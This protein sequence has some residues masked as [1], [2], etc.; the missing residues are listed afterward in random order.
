MKRDKTKVESFAKSSKCGFLLCAILCMLACISL[1]ALSFSSA[2]QTAY[3]YEVVTYNI[4]QDGEKVKVVNSSTNVVIYNEATFKH[5]A[6][7]EAID[8]DR[9][10]N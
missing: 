10:V 7:K 3:A 4:F 6:V 8:L 5:S 9:G 2:T 1:F